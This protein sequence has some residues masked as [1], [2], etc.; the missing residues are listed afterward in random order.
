MWCRV[1]ITK[2]P[3]P[4]GGFQYRVKLSNPKGE[5]V[6]I[7]IEFGEYVFVDAA[8]V[9]VGGCGRKR[10]QLRLSCWRGEDDISGASHINRLRLDGL[11]DGLRG[12]ELWRVWWR[13]G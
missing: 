4:T 6:Q 3:V 1:C 8:V 7:P 2:Y 11:M 9:R 5:F 10:N 13:H 12:L